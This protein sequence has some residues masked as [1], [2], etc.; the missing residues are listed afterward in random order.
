MARTKSLSVESLAPLG[1]DAL[2]ALL[3]SHAEEDAALRK[4]LKLLL[5]GTEG[6]G[7][8][9]AEISKRIQTIGRSRSMID[10]EKRKTVV[11]ELTHLR[12]T[13]ATTLAAQNPKV[14]I[15]LLWDFIALADGVMN[16]LGEPGPVEDIFDAA[17]ADLGRLLAAEPDLDRTELARR[18]QAICDGGGFG[19]SP[20][21]SPV[22]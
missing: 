7:K 8:L 10:W 1:V 15:G 21:P 4:K 2:A 16:R 13:A 5:A 14:A 22:A 20:I 17:M 3:I 6:T 11:Q 12:V 9:A 19:A 18:V